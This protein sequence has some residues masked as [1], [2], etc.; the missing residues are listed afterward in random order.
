MEKENKHSTYT[1]D[2]AFT[3]ENAISLVQLF[4]DFVEKRAKF[5]YNEMIEDRLNVVGE[6]KV[7]Y[8]KSEQKNKQ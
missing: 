4:D 3:E 2:K 8:E 6:P 5:H 7:E 1:N